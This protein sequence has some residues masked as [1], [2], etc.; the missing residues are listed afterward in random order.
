MSPQST[1]RTNITNFT[2]NTKYINISHVTTI[3]LQHQHYYLN[4]PA[5]LRIP[6]SSTLL[7]SPQSTYSTNITNFT[8]INNFLTIP[9]LST[10]LMSP[11]STCS[12]SITNF[13][14]F[15]NNTKI[16]NIS[17]AAV[18]LQHQHYQLY[19]L[20][21]KSTYSTN[22]PALQTIPKLSTFLM[23][24]QSTYSTSITSFTN[25]TKIISISHV[26]TIDLQHQ[27]Y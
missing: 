10:F 7:M 6:K 22:L 15:T 18:E 19:Q 8:N 4:L 12:T 5:L 2:N 27:H 26:A 1:Y 3:N 11:Q 14:S 23:S 21:P 24:P 16:I 25:N 20:W 9:K 17:N 13:N